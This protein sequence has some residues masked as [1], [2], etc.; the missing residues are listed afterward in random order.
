METDDLQL[1][2]L[3]ET[4]NILNIS[5]RT[6]HRLVRDSDNPLP[7]FKLGGDWRIMRGDLERWLNAHKQPKE[8]EVKKVKARV[9]LQLKEGKK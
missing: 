9:V 5:T 6:V 1:L 3:R 2:S 4:A 8:K 7:L